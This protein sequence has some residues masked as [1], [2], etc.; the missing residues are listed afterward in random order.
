MDPEARSHNP[1][2]PSRAPAPAADARAP[3]GIWLLAG[4]VGGGLA[5]I[6]DAVTAV[7]RGVG[8]LGVQKAVWLVVLGASLLGAVGLL[9]GAAIHV[10]R[11]IAARA[12]SRDRGRQA[13]QIA[14][15][16]LTLPLWIYDGIAMFRG[17]RAAQMPGHHFVSLLFAARCPRNIA[18]P[19]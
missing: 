16:L 8:G 1:A 17:H 18:M 7:I 3:R 19:S 14:A 9:A 5:G 15:A 4:V 2:P 12:P 13:V 11:R 10:A 6:G